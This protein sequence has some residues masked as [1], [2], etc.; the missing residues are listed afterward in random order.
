MT[1]VRRDKALAHCDTMIDLVYTLIEK[2]KLF[3]KFEGQEQQEQATKALKT[4]STGSLSKRCITLGISVLYYQEAL[5]SNT[6]EVCQKLSILTTKLWQTIETLRKRVNKLLLILLNGSDRR[7]GGVRHAT[8]YTKKMESL[9]RLLDTCSNKVDAVVAFVQVPS[10]VKTSYYLNQL[11]CSI[12]GSISDYDLEILYSKLKKHIIDAYRRRTSDLLDGKLSETQAMPFTILPETNAE[13]VRNLMA[14]NATRSQLH[15]LYLHKKLTRAEREGFVSRI[16]TTRREP[17][18]EIDSQARVVLQ[19]SCPSPLN[20][21]SSSSPE[22]GDTSPSS[23][24][25]SWPFPSPPSRT[26]EFEENTPTTSSASLK[27]DDIYDSYHDHAHDATLGLPGTNAITAL[28]RQPSHKRS[29]N[30]I[31]RVRSQSSA[32]VSRTRNPV[33]YVAELPVRARASSLSQGRELRSA[34]KPAAVVITPPVCG[35]TRAATMPLD[36][37]RDQYY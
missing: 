22:I 6:G 36:E 7:L 23:A 8:Y 9:N 15:D 34:Q 5:E 29:I 31:V 13:R 20:S 1:L 27:I 4:V 21:N 37:V 35:L 26:T 33:W 10:R 32:S 25:Y 17:K 28:R 19:D 30:E 11:A 24:G 16:V 3:P 14:P 18:W 12:P 2:F